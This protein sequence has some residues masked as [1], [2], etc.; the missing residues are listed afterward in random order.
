MKR[1]LELIKKEKSLGRLTIVSNRSWKQFFTYLR[2]RAT[3]EKYAYYSQKRFREE[4]ENLNIPTSKEF[5]QLFCAEMEKFFE[6]K[7]RH[8]L[9]ISN[10]E[11]VSNLGYKPS[12]SSQTV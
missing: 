4:C 6:Q 3:D 2:N 11:S 1:Y 5:P 7:R 8:C 9:H 12:L 10:K